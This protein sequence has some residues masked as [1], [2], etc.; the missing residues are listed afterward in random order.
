MSR[1]T[2]NSTGRFELKNPNNG[3]D[4]F[5]MAEVHDRFVTIQFGKVGS[6]GYRASRE[7]ENSEA[8][9]QFVAERLKTQIDKGFKP[10]Y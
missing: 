8:A 2:H 3:H 9:D 6:K 5:W 7:F 1:Y 10:V 4:E